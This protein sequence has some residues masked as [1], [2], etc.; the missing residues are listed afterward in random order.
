M[1][2]SWPFGDLRP[3]SYRA[4]LADPP[5][6]YEHYSKAGEKKAA[7]AHYECMSTADICALPVGHLARGDAALVMWATFPMLPDAFKVMDAWGFTYK[8]G[9]AWTKTTKHGKTAFGTG[10]ILRGAAEIYLVG[11][12]GKPRWRS[13]SVRNQIT[14][15]ARG[16]SRKPDQMPRDIERLLDG[17]Y[18]ELFARE[19]RPG[20]DAWG[21]ET[22]KFAEAA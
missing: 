12:V 4:I 3:L 8:T 10:Y 17:P 22:D 9:G 11:T 19:R 21:N 16:H 7:Q 5:W 1:T 2:T 15:P 20:W 18:L 14:A 13:K 6:E